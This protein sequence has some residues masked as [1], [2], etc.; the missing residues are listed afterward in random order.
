MTLPAVETGAIA[1]AA[2]PALAE[3]VPPVIGEVT[4]RSVTHTIDPHTRADQVAAMGSY[5]D[6]AEDPAQEA[7]SP[8]IGRAD[9]P[10]LSAPS[11]PF[12]DRHRRLGSLQDPGG[13]HGNPRVRRGDRVLRAARRRPGAPDRLAP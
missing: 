2:P 9:N 11:V 6:D 3:T 5:P 1:D 13:R 7:A 10:P 8:L 4:A 12:A